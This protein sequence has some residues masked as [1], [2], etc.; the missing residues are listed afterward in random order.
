MD[1]WRALVADVRRGNLAA[2][3][4]VVRRFMGM[5][6]G[7]PYSILGDVGLAEDAAQEAFH[8]P[9]AH[10]TLARPEVRRAMLPIILEAREKD[11]EAGAHIGQALRR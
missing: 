5:A 3:E 9:K 7:Y 8:C 4:A 1:D 6:V 11:I 2:F 10:L